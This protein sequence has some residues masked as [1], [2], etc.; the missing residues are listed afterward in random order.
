MC[1]VERIFLLVVKQIRSKKDI[2]ALCACLTALLTCHSLPPSIRRHTLLFLEGWK[3][4]S[5]F[6]A[7]L[8]FSLFFFIFYLLFWMG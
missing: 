7:L 2:A 8:F 5:I 6:A 3:K 4:L 1:A